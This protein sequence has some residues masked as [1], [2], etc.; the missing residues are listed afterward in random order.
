MAVAKPILQ[1]TCSG[2]FGESLPFITAECL[3]SESYLRDDLDADNFGD[4]PGAGNV[5]KLCGNFMIA[6]E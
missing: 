4:D 5:V 1:T 6:C 2:V 3:L